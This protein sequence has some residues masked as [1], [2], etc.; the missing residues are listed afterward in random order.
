MF[1]KFREYFSHY[2]L[3]IFFLLSFPSLLLGFLLCICCYSWWCLTGLWGCTFFYILCFLHIH[4]TCWFSRSVMSDTLQPHVLK[5][6]RLPCPSP[7]PGACSNSCPLSWWCHPTISSSV[8]P[9]PPAFNLSQNQ[10]LFQW[11]SSLPQV[12]KVLELQHQSF[13]WRFRTDFL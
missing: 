2:F 4:Q 1:I 6:A 3:H 13:Q 7:T 9:S 5:H 10:G 11:V 12:V 8:I